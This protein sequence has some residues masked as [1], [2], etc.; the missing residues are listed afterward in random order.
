MMKGDTMGTIALLEAYT[1][2]NPTSEPAHNNLVLTY[3]SKRM[4]AAAMK[5]IDKMR[6]LGLKVN[7]QFDQM[8]KAGLTLPPANPAPPAATTQTR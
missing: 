7:P 4:Y 5:H 8:I 6:Q 3:I 2:R 1:Q